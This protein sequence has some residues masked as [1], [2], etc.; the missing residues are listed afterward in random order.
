MS[1]LTLVSR[2]CRTSHDWKRNR[3]ELNPSWRLPPQRRTTGGWLAECVQQYHL[4]SYDNFHT[5]SSENGAAIRNKPRRWDLRAGSL[6]RRPSIHTHA[7]ICM[8]I[9]FDLSHIYTSRTASDHSLESDRWY[10]EVSLFCPEVW[11]PCQEK[12]M[13]IRVERKT[14][15]EQRKAGDRFANI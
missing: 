3:D 7:H 6:S 9:T 14:T 1:L 8:F 13:K 10:R 12:T 5:D 2:G 15:A 11:K 4:K